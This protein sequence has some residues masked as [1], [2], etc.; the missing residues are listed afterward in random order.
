MDKRKTPRSL[1]TREALTTRW[2]SVADVLQL[3]IL[4]VEG[5]R[6]V[7]TGQ[8]R[9]DRR[10]SEPAKTE[11]TNFVL[12]RIV[13][14][15]AVIVLRAVIPRDVAIALAGQVREFEVEVPGPFVKEHVG[16]IG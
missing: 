1:F 4:G 9:P 13:G 2:S 5:G 16:Q 14:H 11:G 15:A 6:D 3:V 12:L 7:R 10:A 8:E